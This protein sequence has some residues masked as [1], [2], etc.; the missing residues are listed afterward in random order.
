MLEH[1]VGR[2]QIPAS[3]EFLSL[4]GIFFKKK[5]II[6]IGN[7]NNLNNKIMPIIGAVAAKV[8]GLNLT[9]AFRRHAGLGNWQP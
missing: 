7:D 3:F 2:C 8:L 1:V 4:V 5:Y 6:K 9:Q